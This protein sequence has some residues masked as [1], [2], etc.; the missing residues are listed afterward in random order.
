MSVVLGID[1]GTSGTRK[2]FINQQWKNFQIIKETKPDKT[3]LSIPAQYLT[4]RRLSFPINDRKK[5]KEIIK[6]ELSHSLLFYDDAIWD[7]APIGGQDYLVTIARKSEINKLLLKNKN[8][9]PTNLEA[10][11][12]SLARA[13][14]Y[15]GHKNALLID[16]G[17][18]KTIL[19]AIAGEKL[20]GCK[21]I[22]IGGNYLAKKLCDK[23]SLS[24][25]QAEKEKETMSAEHPVIKDF[26]NELFNL[27]YIRNLN[28]PY[29]LLSG[30]GG[31]LN[32]LDKFLQEKYKLK[33]KY[34]ETEPG[35]ASPV[36][37][38]GALKGV[39]PNDGVDLKIE[40]EERV[41]K[42]Y[43]PWLMLALG[44]FLLF[45]FDIKFKEMHY[46]GKYNQINKKMISL[47]K[48][49]FPELKNIADPLKQI[50]SI[51]TG[52][53]KGFA[54][55]DAAPLEVLSKTSRLMDKK[56]FKIFEINYS[57][58][59]IQLI[60]EASSINAINGLAEKLKNKFNKIEPSEIKADPTGKINFVLRVSY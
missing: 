5:I 30:G 56:D 38:G 55:I 37:L 18:T 22:L 26:L 52:E 54:T 3:I 16:F 42:I 8:I 57:T 6:E 34:L 48:K 24:P 14:L 53:K 13:A 29:L 58:D 36:A 51:V 31:K 33:I 39:F 1:P 43:N 9:K 19:C 25:E 49:E 20:T 44:L 2:L 7:M 47:T 4:F 35:I 41:G 50:K 21:V 32:G 23:L 60:G 15:Y 45:S 40:R 46:G 59:S 10:E 12:H 28:Y 17:A 27:I 11:P